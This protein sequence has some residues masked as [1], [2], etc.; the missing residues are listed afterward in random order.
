M[1][2]EYQDKL[3]WEATYNSKEMISRGCAMT[4]GGSYV[5]VPLLP[6]FTVWTLP[7]SD[8]GVAA[9]EPGYDE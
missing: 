2:R 6:T 1:Q 9:G 8:A 4:N 5:R 3:E 7:W